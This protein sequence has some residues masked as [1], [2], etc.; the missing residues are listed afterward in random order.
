MQLLSV[1]ST[2]SL[3][4]G[5]ADQPIHPKKS[6]ILTFSTIM[7]Y[8]VPLTLLLWAVAPCTIDG[9]HSSD[10]SFNIHFLFADCMP[11]HW[12]AAAPLF[13][14]RYWQSI[15]L[16]SCNEAADLLKGELFLKSKSC[17]VETV[18]YTV[19]KAL[20]NWQ[21]WVKILRAQCAFAFIS[22][23]PKTSVK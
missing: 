15:K 19:L 11:D 13:H 17:L 23:A 4:Q 22:G 16:I 1:C 12:C 18:Q 3:A 14:N 10:P 20:Q 6:H 5:V 8:S 21:Y 9:K 7:A 2:R